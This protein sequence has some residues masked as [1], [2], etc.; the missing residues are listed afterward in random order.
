MKIKSLILSAFVLLSGTAY[1]GHPQDEYGSFDQIS[2]YNGGELQFDIFG[3]YAFADDEGISFF[4]EDT[5]GGGLA[6]NYFVT[7]HIGFGLE[8]MVF[9]TDGDTFG[10]GA[11]NLY[12]RAPLGDTG[13][14]IY[15]FGGAGLVVNAENLNEEDFE[16]ARDRYNDDTEASDSDDVLFE[17]HIGIG[18]EVRLNEH[19]GIF[20]DLRHT[21]VERDD[22]DYSSARAGLRIAF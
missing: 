7:R 3:T 17:A 9:D 2:L 6:L 14:A 18:A 15:G 22:S 19:L 5:A 8:G 10:S 13:V 20:T 11:L 4:D 21:F 12:L 1:A 16:E